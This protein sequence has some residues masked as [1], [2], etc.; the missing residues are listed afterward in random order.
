MQE[1]GKQQAA[2]VQA[3]QANASLTRDSARKDPAGRDQDQGNTG[4]SSG[5]KK[6]GGK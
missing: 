3:Y 5:V 4:S 2:Q 1:Q 6:E